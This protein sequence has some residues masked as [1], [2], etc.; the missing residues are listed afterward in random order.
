MKR[1]IQNKLIFI[2][3]YIFV[4][5]YSN[6]QCLNSIEDNETNKIGFVNEKGDTIVPLIYDKANMLYYKFN[7]G[8]CKVAQFDRGYGYIDSTGKEIIPC[9]Y[10]Y[11]GEEHDGLIAAVR[12]E[13]LSQMYLNR[14][15]D[16][17]LDLD[18][19]KG[20]PRDFHNGLA[21][22]RRN[23]RF[24]YIG[25]DGEI[26]I[27]IE[28]TDGTDFSNG[29]AD[30][31]IDTK[32]YSVDVHGIK[33]KEK[34][35]QKRDI[36]HYIF[37]NDFI[38]AASEESV[39]DKLIDYKLAKMYDAPSYFWYQDTCRWL[40]Y[41]INTKVINRH[42]SSQMKIYYWI[43]KI[44][45]HDNTN[46]ENEIC[47][48]YDKN[49]EIIYDY[50]VYAE[51]KNG[52]MKIKAKKNKRDCFIRKKIEKWYLIVK[53]YGIEYVRDHKIEPL[54]KMFYEIKALK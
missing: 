31:S 9:S 41:Q 33:Y 30:V 39:L 7:N 11:L 49:H 47:V 42:V 26:V 6:S 48:F 24:G 44:Y 25:K 28:Y 40:N 2:C 37:N 10:L 8:I 4:F 29:F 54:P 19:I 38:N 5:Q 50:D 35:C 22:I 34:S 15:G 1:I 21:L 14:E 52:I 23:G 17:I 45:N 53:K 36:E 32:K 27:P 16:V 18:S 3:A 51:Y 20:I 43:I 13:K 46:N 12:K